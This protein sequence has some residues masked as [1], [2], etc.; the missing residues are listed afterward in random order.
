MVGDEVTELSQRED[1]KEDEEQRGTA[2][3][4]AGDDG[5]AQ[6]GR[7]DRGAGAYRRRAERQRAAAIVT[8]RLRSAEERRV[9]GGFARS[10]LDLGRPF[11]AGAGERAAEL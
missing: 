7:E 4:H 9:R 6:D 11:R 3:D 8:K 2:S 10:L 5:R 1:E